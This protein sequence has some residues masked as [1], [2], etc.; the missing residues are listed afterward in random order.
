METQGDLIEQAVKA[1]KLT[2]CPPRPA[3]GHKKKRTRKGERIRPC[4]RCFVP[5][6][7][8]NS[9]WTAFAQRRKGWHWVNEDGSHH[10]CGDFRGRA[11]YFAERMIGGPFRPDGSV[12]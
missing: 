11:L 5:I 8:A 1:G 4:P 9:T 7:Y 10:R 3:M 12:G 6:R 2:V